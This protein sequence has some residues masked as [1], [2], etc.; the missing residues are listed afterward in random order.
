MRLITPLQ[1]CRHLSIFR[2]Y[3]LS[4]LKSSEIVPNFGRFFAFHNFRGA[5]PQNLYPHSNACLAARYLKQFRE[6]TPLDPKVITANTLNFKSACKDAPCIAPS[7]VTEYFCCFSELISPNRP[8]ISLSTSTDY[9]HTIRMPM[10]S[11]S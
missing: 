2:I 1:G 9:F 5:G 8:C 3:S 11:V 6:V 10:L 7:R 4:N